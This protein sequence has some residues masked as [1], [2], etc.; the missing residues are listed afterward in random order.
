M[1]ELIG[2]AISTLAN[3]ADHTYV[4]CGT[5]QCAWG[6]W[7]RKAGGRALRS[8]PASTK[9]ADKIAQPD[10]RANIKCYL[11]NGVCHQ[12]A[13]RILLPAA[14]TVRGARG[15]GISEA[16]FGVYGRV[17]VF[18][19]HGPF[20]RYSSVSGDLPE[21][22]PRVPARPTGVQGLTDAARLDWLYIRS[23]VALYDQAEDVA[24]RLGAIEPGSFEMT[25]FMHMAEFR[26]GPALDGK[27]AARLRSR[28]MR[29]ERRRRPLEQAWR[30]GAIRPREFVD[31]I[32][33]VTEQFQEDMANLMTPIQYKD[34]F[35]LDPDERV[36]L[37]DEE[38]VQREMLD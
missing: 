31:G 21:C 24:G 28:R 11:V 6:C 10:E 26:L 9:R 5:T 2:K 7:G 25:L 19:C 18:P 23:V 32:N 15:Y 35:E 1:G 30:E 3:Q 4:E 8:G 29:V 38:I 16:L 17:G 27:L 14:I 22:I 33:E 12:A 13:N 34:M 20:N 37:A 36:V